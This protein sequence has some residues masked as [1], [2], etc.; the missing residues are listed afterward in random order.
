MPTTNLP[1]DLLT[2]RLAPPWLDGEATLAAIA[3]RSD[4]SASVLDRHK[5]DFCCRGQRSLAEACRTAGLDVNGILAELDAEVSSR[6]GASVSVSAW[7]E[8][9]LGEFVDF[10]VRTHHAYTR[11]ALAHI[12]PLL[13]KVAGKH[14][15]RH[16]Q[17][18]RV[19]V[20]F[21]ALAAELGP[22]ML[23][24]E[25]ILFPYIQS[26]GAPVAPARPPFGTIKN[27]VRVMMTEHDRAAELLA[28]IA[29]A[30][31][32]FSPPEDAC[33][34][35]RALYVAL[36]ELRLD[37]LRH[38]SLENNVLFPRAAAAEEALPTR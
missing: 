33:T 4:A 16:P 21:Q 7:S 38:V 31:Q 14:G 28:T 3:L 12:T 5:L 17:L 29:D 27:P 22:H 13:A 9:P 11:A 6:S 37:L 35:F 2:I 25:R 30:T 8:R 24:E 15:E 19:D 34:S 18:A 26:M 20:A 1:K 32:T 36:R 10:I 23:R